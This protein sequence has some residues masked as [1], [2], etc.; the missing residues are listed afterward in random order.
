MVP[1]A[2]GVCQLRAALVKLPQELYD[3][4]ETLTFAYDGSSRVLSS[5][6]KPPVQL[7]INREIRRRF[8][9][10]FYGAQEPW[11]A[12]LDDLEE[13]YLLLNRWLIYWPRA[14]S[15]E[16]L[17]SLS[18]LPHSGIPIPSRPTY[19]YTASFNFGI[20]DMRR[21]MSGNGHYRNGSGAM[22]QLRFKAFQ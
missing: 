12:P 11:T 17:S 8:T 19:Y 21:R 16:A 4:I 22:A 10:E 9:K 15:E 5:K 2:L 1:I 14:L 7:Q 3:E 20:M 6:W 13:F 18:K